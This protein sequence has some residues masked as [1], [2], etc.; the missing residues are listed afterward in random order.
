VTVAAGLAAWDVVAADWDDIVRAI[1][2][3]NELMCRLG[4]MWKPEGASP[5]ADWLLTQ[6]FGYLG[7][8]VTSSLVLGMSENALL[9]AL[10]LAYMQ[11]AGGMN[12][13]S[14]SPSGSTSFRTCR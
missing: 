6:L 9:S 7:A 13:F 3:G 5:G 4:L 10:G 12:P 14:R 11:A 8:A 1:L 2:V